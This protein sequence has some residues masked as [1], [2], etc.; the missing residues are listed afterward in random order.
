MKVEIIQEPLNIKYV[1]D[2]EAHA[3]CRQ[4]GTAVAKRLKVEVESGS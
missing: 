1:P 3:R 2:N 4:L